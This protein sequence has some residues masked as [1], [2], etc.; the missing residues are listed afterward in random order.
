MAKESLEE[1][2]GGTEDG[3]AVGERK[4][5]SSAFP[6]F[7][8]FGLA[9]AEVGVVLGVFVLT[10]VGVIAFTGS[11][12]GILAES[13]Y[14]ADGWTTLA[15]LGVVVLA[16]GAVV[17]VRYGG[18]VGGVEP[19]AVPNDIAYRGLSMLAA[20]ALT[21]LTAGAGYARGELDPAA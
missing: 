12:A 16:L 21:L 9:V 19:L 4:P 18:S 3:T 20:G 6:M 17:F 11:V 8:A 1:A 15:V 5:S 10:V 14:V 2:G 13:G 7:L